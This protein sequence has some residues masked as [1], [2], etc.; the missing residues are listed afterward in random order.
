MHMLT[1]ASTSAETP[2][3]DESWAA[4][5]WR[6]F[7]RRRPAVAGLALIA[8]FLVMALAAPLLSHYSPVDQDLSQ[9]L[10]SPSVH[11]LFGTDNLGRDLATR[12][13][14]GA[15]L[16]LLMGVLAVAIGLAVGLPLG[17]ISGYYGGVVDLLVQR[18]TDIL[19]SFPVLLLALALVATLGVGL[20]N[21]IIAVGISTIPV[22]IRIVR[23]SVLVIREQTYV[24]AARSIGNSD[25]RIIWRH[26]LSNALAPIIV[27]AS[28]SIGS[29][30]LVAAGLGFLGLGVQP[31]TPEWGAMLGEGKQYI[32]A[33]ANLV[34][35]PGLAIFLA[36]LAFNLLGDGLQDALD[37]RLRNL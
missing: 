29:T 34:T 37:P 26:V 36:V 27:Q 4:A 24:E 22:F 19:L 9:A 32:F 6:R 35:F 21:A 18:L 28:L 31:P 30:I 8:L 15:R 13:L 11:H 23:G 1:R 25:W 14:Y 10:R 33:A 16:S 7:R 12:L 3:G 20:Q 17:A 2:G 5:T